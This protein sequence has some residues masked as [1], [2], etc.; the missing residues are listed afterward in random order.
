MQAGLLSE[1]ALIQGA[2]RRLASG[3]AAGAYAA[4]QDVLRRNRSSAPARLVLGRIAADHRNWAAATDLFAEAAALA[5]DA[6]GQA[7]GLAHEARCLIA[8]NRQ[9][10]ARPLLDQ[11]EALQPRDALTLDTLGVART[12]VGDLDEGRALFEQVVTLQPGVAAFQYNLAAARQFAGD[13]DGAETA[14]RAALAVEPDHP[15]AWSSLVSLRKQTTRDA[16]PE[17]QRLFDAAEGD[18]VRRLHL[19][20]AIAKTLEDLGEAE[21]SLAWLGRA[22]ALRRAAV[23]SPIAHDRAVFEAAAGLGPAPAPGHPGDRPVFIVGLPRSGTTLLDRVLS[24]HP[25]VASA[26][27]LSDFSIAVKRMAGTPSERVLD[28]ETLIAARALDRAEIGRRYLEMTQRR[29]LAAGSPA[30]LIDK[31]PLN[32]LYAGLIH[33]ALPDARIIAL[34]RHPVDSALANYRQ[35]FATDFPFYDYGLDL[36]DAGAYYALFDGLMAH[37]RET[38]PPDR[39]TEVWYEDLVADLE[40]QTRRLLAFLGLDWDPACLDFHANTAPVTTASSVQVRSPLYASSVGRW[41]RYGE[42]L[43]PLLDALDQAGIGY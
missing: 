28:P 14:Y 15:R 6:E 29:W 43:R 16:L 9:A 8:R 32:S 42:G 37:W 12:R 5:D 13:M 1:A 20:H 40:G 41:R 3:D 26:G 38:L 17:L 36:A 27:E 4:A 10:E 21:D 11:A 2:L 35:L 33:Q 39:F 31:M 24:S 18:A 25:D 22:K 19:G 34:R 7:A 30:R 23:G